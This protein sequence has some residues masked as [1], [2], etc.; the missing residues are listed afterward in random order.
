[1]E[2][3]RRFERVQVETNHGFFLLENAEWKPYDADHPYNKS[4]RNGVLRGFCV[5]GGTTARL[6]HAVSH[7]D[8]SGKVQT[9]DYAH[10][11]KMAIR[12]NETIPTFSLVSCG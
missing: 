12:Y 4:G 3:A 2:Q 8:E 5:K 7:R 6:F 11:D 1:M 9:F 10:L